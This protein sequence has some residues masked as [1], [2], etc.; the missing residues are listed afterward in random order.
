MGGGGGKQGP[1]L[2]S[3]ARASRI[4]WW[5]HWMWVW[6][7]VGNHGWLWGF[8]PDSWVNGVNCRLSLFIS[9]LC[10]LLF[11][12][13]VAPISEPGFQVNNSPVPDCFTWCV[14]SASSDC[15]P[16]GPDR[17]PLFYKV[18]LKACLY[19]YAAVLAPSPCQTPSAPGS[20]HTWIPGGPGAQA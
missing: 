1:F 15:S 11:S 7:E 14:S 19:K 16:L 13:P 2:G 3:S 12:I 5:I 17:S 4:A 9:L 10:H 20:G 18:Q 6:R 8:G